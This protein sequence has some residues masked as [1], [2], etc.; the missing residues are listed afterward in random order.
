MPVSVGAN[1]M[2]VVHAGSGGVSIGIPDVCKTPAPP[3]PPIP[4]PYPNVAR[5][6]DASETATKVKVDGHPLCTKD[7]C[8][9]TSTGDEAGT[10]GGVASSTTK[11]RA[12][13]VGYSMDVVVGGKPI[14]RALDPMTHNDDN[15]PPTPLIQGPVVELP[16]S[17]PVLCPICEKP[18]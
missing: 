11:G 9:R 13:F 3:A 6:R 8:F 17:D 10:V 7:S 18:L 12:R 1:F 14:P 4:V 2:S 5:S 16:S 15:C